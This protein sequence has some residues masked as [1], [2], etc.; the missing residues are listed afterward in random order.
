MRSRDIGGTERWGL[1]WRGDGVTYGGARGNPGAPKVT[2]DERRN[3]PATGIYRASGW[4]VT[5]LITGNLA[6]RHHLPV[7]VTHTCQPLV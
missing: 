2:S 6:R 1:G 3:V 5:S 4:L 7:A